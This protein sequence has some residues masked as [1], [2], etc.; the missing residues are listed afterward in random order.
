MVS[1]M[2]RWLRAPSTGRGLLFVVVAATS[3]GVGGFVA[4]ILHRAGG[5]GLV[6][7]SFWRFV[8]GLVLLAAMRPLVKRRRRWTIKPGQLVLT[9]IGFAVYQTAYYAAVPLAGLAAATIVT[10]GLG[11][12]LIAIGSRAFLGERLRLRGVITIV[13]ALLGL[14][15]LT[16]DGSAGSS[17]VVGLLLCVLS[18]AGYAG[19]TLLRHGRSEGDPYDAALGGFGVAACC[20]L[21]LA[22]LEGIRPPVYDIGWLVFL[23]VA[24]TALAYAL[25]FVGLRSLRATT[26]SLV[27]LV[28]QLTA[29]VLAVL[30]LHERLTL[31]AAAGG[32]LL[33]G[34]VALRAVEEA[35]LSGVRSP[36]SGRRSTDRSAEAP[37][38]PPSVPGP[39]R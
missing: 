37:A 9:G 30:V 1:P 22:L 24:P 2:I 20:V 33:M 12:V 10:L 25:F 34:A 26:A 23:G 38:A 4:A 17:P 14:V 28:E 5:L 36:G 29:A 27:A 15:L 8:G 19:V 7:V 18:A 31:V 16:V 11:P 35:R 32:A 13:V 39:A 21:P 6:A 3:W